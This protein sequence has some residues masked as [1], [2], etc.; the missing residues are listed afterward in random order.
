LWY[1][2]LKK[3]KSII[4]SNQFVNHSTT[5]NNFQHSSTEKNLTMRA[6][7]LLACIVLAQLAISSAFTFPGLSH[8]AF[9]SG[10]DDMAVAASHKEEHH[11]SGFEEDGGSE[12]GSDHHS[13]VQSES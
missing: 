1:I 12:H 11:S 2:K 4:R 8:E 3:V 9:H 10:D 13:K 5:I 6:W 7:Q